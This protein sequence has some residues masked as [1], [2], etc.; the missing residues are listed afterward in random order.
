VKVLQVIHG[1]G[2]GGAETW[3]ISLLRYWNNVA[4]D[5][6]VE[7]HFLLT[8][9]EPVEFDAEA[10][11]LGATL[12]YCRSTRWN[13]GKFVSFYR[14]LL[15][16][17]RFDAIHSHC[18]Y[19]SGWHFGLG[20][21]ILPKVRIA[22]VHNPRLHIT[23]NYAI[24]PIRRCTT[25]IGKFLVKTL[26][27]HVC[28]TSGQI[29]GEY[30]FCPGDS[31]PEVSVL[32]CGFDVA[33]FE[34][35]ATNDRLSIRNEFGWEP[36]AKIVLFAGRLDRKI[37]FDHPT[38]HK[39]SWFALNVV[40]YAAERDSLL[41]CV[42]A[43]AGAESKRNL[44][45]VVEQWGLSKRIQL[46]GVRHDIPRLMRGSDLLLF[47]SR[48]EGLGMVAVEA[49]AANLPVIASDAVPRECVVVPDICTFLP[50]VNGPEQWATHVI[51]VLS[52]ERPDM[53]HSR[54]AVRN[55]PFSIDYSAAALERIYR[56]EQ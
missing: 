17:E 10:Q 54:Q 30:G 7:T 21:G 43:G 6:Q 16:R 26:G 20:L 39:N 52:R 40:R 4:T 48:Q 11:S 27:T 19:V 31:R 29:L 41:C 35:D 13:M 15:H 3:L 9:G 24:S 32:H 12:H 56:G 2:T 36:Q 28:G 46:V 8:G 1:L 34:G 33:K 37:E 55:S 47:P 14:T 22:H 25:A 45:A 42:M 53:R 38:N 44:Q 49:Q 23:A 50:L 51:S 5:R 18:D